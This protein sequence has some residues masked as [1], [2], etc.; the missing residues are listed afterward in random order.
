MRDLGDNIKIHPCCQT[1][2]KLCGYLHAGMNTQGRIYF[3]NR[4]FVG[5]LSKAVSEGELR[6]EFAPFGTIRIVKIVQVHDRPHNYGFVTYESNEEAQRAMRA[7]GDGI[8]L[9][10]RKIQVNAAFKSGQPPA[11]P[12]DILVNSIKSNIDHSSLWNGQ[13]Q[14][15]SPPH[16]DM[17][18][19]FLYPHGNY[20]NF[21]YVMPPVPSLSDNIYAYAPGLYAMMPPYQS[22]FAPHS[23]PSPPG[24]EININDISAIEIPLSSSTLNKSDSGVSSVVPNFSD[25]AEFPDL[26]GSLEDRLGPTPE[27]FTDRMFLSD[28]ITSGNT[29]RKRRQRNFSSY[30]RLNFYEN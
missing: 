24:T 13:P 4:V 17:F 15:P 26:G 21:E 19:N 1:G 29:F 23:P 6:Q 22:H 5:G 28:P 3:Y 11:P 30:A 12:Q 9:G 16:L 18:G 7:G 20:M 27:E 25:V 2:I 8:F 14:M 10:N